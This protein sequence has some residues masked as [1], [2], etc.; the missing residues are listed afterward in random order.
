M[1]YRL[2]TLLIVLALAPPVLA[3]A[4][5]EAAEWVRH[6]QQPPITWAEAVRRAKAVSN[7]GG[8]LIG[9]ESKQRCGK[10]RNP[11]KSQRQ[12]G[13]ENWLVGDAGGKS[14]G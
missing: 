7:R 6:C 2:R 5:R 10:S 14:P 4:G 9:E 12:V 13:G 1:R 11:I 3:C 8:G